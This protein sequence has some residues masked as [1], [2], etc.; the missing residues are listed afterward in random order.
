MQAAALAAAAKAGLPAP[1]NPALVANPQLQAALANLAQAAAANQAAAVVAA[2]L[3]G[4]TFPS[5]G[6]A[7][8]AGTGVPG[9]QMMPNMAQ[10]MASM[11]MS[12]MGQVSNLHQIANQMTLANMAGAMGHLGSPMLGIGAGASATAGLTDGNPAA[13][14]AAMVAAY[15][16]QNNL[17]KIQADM[18]PESYEIELEINDF[19]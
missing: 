3:P 4:M 12:N 1:M 6:V 18:A 17:S 2:G 19:P 13:R 5:V 16:L 14:A 15:N 11:G 9:L 7:G 8:L 10:I